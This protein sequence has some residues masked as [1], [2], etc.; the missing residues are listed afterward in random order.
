MHGPLG[1][2][3]SSERRSVDTALERDVEDGHGTSEVLRERDVDDGAPEV[4]DRP[5]RGRPGDT[6]R[7]ALPGVLPQQP[8]G[9]GRLPL[10]IDDVDDLGELTAPGQP[11]QGEG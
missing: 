8:E 9:L 1:V 6:Q 5:A 2:Q 11:V 7:P 10:G 4:R 3:L